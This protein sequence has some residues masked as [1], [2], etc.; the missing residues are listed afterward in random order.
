MSNYKR[1]LGGISALYMCA[2]SSRE[3]ALVG[4]PEELKIETLEEGSSYTETIE[5]VGTSQRVTHS[6]VVVTDIDTQLNMVNNQGLVAWIELNAGLK[7]KVGYSPLAQFDRP[8]RLISCKNILGESRASRPC[9][10]WLF[11]SVDGVSA[12]N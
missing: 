6:L 4:P 10:Q 12:L 2:A 3:A 1:P 5:S 11:S 9:K 8:L 7:I